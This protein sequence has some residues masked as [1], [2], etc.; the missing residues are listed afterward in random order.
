MGQLSLFELQYKYIMDASSLISQRD[1]EPHNKRTF[2][3]LWHN[4]ENLIDAGKIV[5]CSEIAVELHD[6]DVTSWLSSAHCVIIPIDDEIQRN[7]IKVVTTYP[8]LVDIGRNKSSGDP[9]LIATAMKYDLTVI[10]EE[11]KDSPRKI[12]QVC[13]CMGI[14]CIN[15][16][17]LCLREGWIF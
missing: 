2:Q 5:T 12:P 3:T 8:R 16:N 7:V 15:I 4:I 6:N 13:G 1:G 11:G 17:E 9:F 14:D 10:T